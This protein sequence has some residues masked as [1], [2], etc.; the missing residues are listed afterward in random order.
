LPREHARS[1]FTDLRSEQCVVL[2]DA[3]IDFLVG[4]N[5]L[6]TKL[7]RIFA[8]EVLGDDTNPGH[9]PSDP[10]IEFAAVPVFPG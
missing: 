7:R 5:A 9:Q 2:S 6:G 1:D 4:H 8:N 10:A 3:A